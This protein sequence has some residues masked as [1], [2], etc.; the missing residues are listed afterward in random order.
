MQNDQEK[1]FKPNNGS[2]EACGFGRPGDCFPGG[3]GDIGKWFTHWGEELRKFVD[4]SVN[5]ADLFTKLNLVAA[6][7]DLAEVER[8]LKVMD[9]DK[10]Q[11]TDESR[12]V[13]YQHKN[14]IYIKLNET[15]NWDV[16]A[17]HLAPHFNAKLPEGERKLSA[18]SV[19]VSTAVPIVATTL[20]NGAAAAI[21]TN[22]APGLGLAACTLIYQ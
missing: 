17:K 4:Q 9:M 21:L 15:Y 10:A 8:L 5:L 6:A 11:F 7:V 12:Y 20:T 2:L 18:C 13:F 14:E 3:G 1:Q 19:L 16:L 22:T